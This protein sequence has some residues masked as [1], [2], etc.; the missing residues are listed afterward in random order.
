MTHVVETE[1]VGEYR[2]EI[3]LDTDPQNP[4]REYDHAVTMVCFHGRYNL[5]DDHE[6]HKD[7]YS[8]WDELRKAIEKHEKPVAIKPLYLYDHSGLALSIEAFSDPWDSGQV[9]WAYLT[10]ENEEKFGIPD[11]EKAI[12]A[13]IEE[14]AAYLSGDVYGF[15]VYLGDEEVASCWGFYGLD[16]CKEAAREE[17]DA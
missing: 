16:Y 1:E 6:Y 10:P 17:V 8:S 3:V 15:R 5:G 4:R 12:E 2:I 9:G 13:E 14:Y 11:A 7:D